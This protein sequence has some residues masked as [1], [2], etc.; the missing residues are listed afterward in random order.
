MEKRKTWSWLGP[1]QNMGM[2]MTNRLTEHCFAE[3]F[4]SEELCSSKAEELRLPV[5]PQV[6]L[7]IR[8]SLWSC[9]ILSLFAVSTSLA[10]A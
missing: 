2:S 7:T 4:E 1:A 3:H 8:G 10:L 6:C 5:A 9:Y